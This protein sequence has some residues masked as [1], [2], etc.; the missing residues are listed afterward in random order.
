MVKRKDECLFCKKRS[1]Y[2]RV[3]SVDG[4]WQYDEVACENHVLDLRKHSDKVN[5]RKHFISSA[6]PQK[7]HDKFLVDEVI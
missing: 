5:C 3:V 6:C 2:E 7:R 4:G 1:C